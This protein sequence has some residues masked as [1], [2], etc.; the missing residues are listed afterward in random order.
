MQVGGANNGG[1]V[2]KVTTSGTLSTLHS[3]CSQ[4]GCADGQYPAGGLFQD[5]NGNLY[6]TTADGGANGFGTVFSLSVGLG[7]FVTTN[8]SIGVVGEIVTIIGYGLNGAT[9]VT[10]NGTPATI[11]KTDATVIYAKVPIGATTGKVVVTT[12]S[13]TFTSNVVF[14]VVP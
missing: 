9:G 13:G 2:F 3:F 5:T 10:F 11:L 4:S 7:A 8:P 1:T 12:P 14:E 6:G